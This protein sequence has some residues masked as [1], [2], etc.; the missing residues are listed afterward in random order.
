ME[1]AKEE[2]EKLITEVRKEREKGIFSSK[3]QTLL[4]SIDQKVELLKLNPVAGTPIKKRMI[5][6]KYS[7]LT[8]L[9]KI[10]LANYWR[11]LYTLSTNEIE[12]AAFVLEITD[13]EKYD[14][15]FGYRGK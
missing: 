2:Y 9:W 12:I 3:N 15:V 4:R 11:M 5:P 6:R 10:N 14:K 1:E 13:H 8:N 7:E